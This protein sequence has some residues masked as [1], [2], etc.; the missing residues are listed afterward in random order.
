MDQQVEIKSGEERELQDD[1]RVF[2]AN[3]D[4]NI[5]TM[6]LTSTTTTLHNT[7]VPLH[8]SRTISSTT[9]DNN[10]HQP[11]LTGSS[12][13][14]TTPPQNTQAPV[15]AAPVPASPELN[16]M[17]LQ[18]ILQQNQQILTAMTKLIELLSINRKPKPLPL[19]KFTSDSGETLVQFLDRYEN[20]CREMYPDSKEGL[21]P[22]LGTYLEGETLDVYKTIV[23]NTWD[24]KDAR[25]Q[26]LTWFREEKARE[27]KHDQKF[28]RST[29]S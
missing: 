17:F 10:Y 29:N 3:D 27:N 22:L 8:V 25:E 9:A 24:Y 5:P 14:G 26:L 13:S 11:T 16:A 19:G 23:R 12:S 2:T 15:A 21:L 6:S 1:G 20:Y 28:H 18:T 7:Y 4:D